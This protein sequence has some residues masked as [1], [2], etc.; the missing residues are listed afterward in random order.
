[1]GIY[2][3]VFDAQ[4]LTHAETIEM[5]ATKIGFVAPNDDFLNPLATER[6]DL[7]VSRMLNNVQNAVDTKWR[8]RIHAQ[9]GS[10]HERGLMQA[11]HRYHTL[12][13]ALTRK[14]MSLSSDDL[15]S[16]HDNIANMVYSTAMPLVFDA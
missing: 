14:L 12:L 15:R 5:F 6:V 16:E 1:M 9:T 11:E 7:I 3:D 8:H 10:D 13:V 4:I 2:I